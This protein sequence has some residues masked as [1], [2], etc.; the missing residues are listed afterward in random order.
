ML[1]SRGV[2]EVVGLI[3]IA[4]KDANVR[5]A[6]VECFAPDCRFPERSFL[7]WD[8][9]TRQRKHYSWPAGFKE[10]WADYAHRGRRRLV[11]ASGNGPPRT[12]FVEAGGQYVPR[13]ELAHLYTGTALR[14]HG[15]PEGRH[16]TQSANLVCM[17]R[18]LHLHIDGASGARLLWFLRG[19]SYLN[20]KYDPL[21]AFS[22]AQPNSYG[23]VDGFGCEGFWP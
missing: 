21:G 6:L 12:A 20:L 14:K 16:F 19:L 22:Q 1:N 11:K 23:F 8:G 17:P 18:P 10:K 15:L 5:K 9:C 2:T 7:L 4:G 13:C 3:R